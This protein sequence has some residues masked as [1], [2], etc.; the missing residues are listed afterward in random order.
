MKDLDLEREVNK[1]NEFCN[2]R[3]VKNTFVNYI[4]WKNNMK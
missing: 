2:K 1:F 4:W 3:K